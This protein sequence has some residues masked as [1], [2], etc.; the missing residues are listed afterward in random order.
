MT[1]R[2]LFTFTQQCILEHPEKKKAVADLYYL[3]LSEIE[4]GGSEF[5]ECELA[6]H[7]MLDVINDQSTED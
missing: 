2:E 4:E 3:A 6:Y 1:K 7:D 5:Y